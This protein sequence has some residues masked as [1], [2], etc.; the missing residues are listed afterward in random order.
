[1]SQYSNHYPEAV[2]EVN[3]REEQYLI[4]YRVTWESGRFDHSRYCS[5]F[6]NESEATGFARWLRDRNRM[7]QPRNIRVTKSW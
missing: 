6:Y 4:T 3:E 1:M 5:L 2:A 7:E